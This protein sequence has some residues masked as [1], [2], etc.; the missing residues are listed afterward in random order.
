MYHLSPEVQHREVLL[1]GRLSVAFG[2]VLGVW[3]FESQ[4]PEV[5][6]DISGIAMLIF[7]VLFT[8]KSKMFSMK[9]TSS[10][11]FSPPSEEY[12]LQSVY[13]ASYWTFMPVTFLLGAF[14]ASETLGSECSAYFLAKLVGSVAMLTYGSVILWELR[15]ENET[16]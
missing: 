9:I 13:K 15:D 3:L 10:Q 16:E 4:L 8:V 11:M 6:V 14:I 2:A 12:L 1:G 5:V 7:I